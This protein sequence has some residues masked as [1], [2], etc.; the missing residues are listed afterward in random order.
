MTKNKHPGQ[1]KT[2]NPSLSK[3][4]DPIS[5]HKTTTQQRY[6]KKIDSTKVSS[7]SN[8]QKKHKEAEVSDS[9]ASQSALSPDNS[10][11]ANIDKEESISNTMF[12]ALSCMNSLSEHTYATPN[13]ATRIASVAKQNTVFIVEIS[14]IANETKSKSD[15]VSLYCLNVI[16]AD[17]ERLI[18]SVLDL[19][20]QKLNKNL[21]F[22]GIA[23]Q[24][25][26]VTDDLVKSFVRTEL[27]IVR[28]IPIVKSYRIGKHFDRKIRPIV[29]KL[30]N[31]ND[32]QDIRF[33]APKHLKGKSFGVNEHF[34]H[35]VV[36]IHKELLPIHKEA[37]KQKLKSV[38]KR[39]KLYIDG[40][41]FDKIK[42]SHLIKQPETMDEGGA[43]GGN[44]GN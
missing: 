6:H 36:E 33:A 4:Y 37:R 32:R 39:D 22:N 42:H 25:D 16:K 11:L 43:Q 24:T 28:E 12:Y 20:Y 9:S 3:Y 13:K 26:E 41:L 29:V 14:K 23:E 18:L 10:K 34:L 21:V 35:E 2:I 1:N 40:E 38:L 27:E 30:E 17:N 5:Y 31:R 44:D 8:P 15:N 19:Q 7:T